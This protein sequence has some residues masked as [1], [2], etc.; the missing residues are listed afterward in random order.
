MRRFFLQVVPLVYAWLR[1]PEDAD[2]IREDLYKNLAIFE[3]A[4]YDKFF[5]GKGSP[6]QQYNVYMTCYKYSENVLK[7]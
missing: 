3:E 6:N 4:L 2:T 7:T 1:N 5:G